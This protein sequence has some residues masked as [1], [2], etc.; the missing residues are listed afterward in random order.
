MTVKQG[1]Q[2]F[3]LDKKGTTSGVFVRPSQ[4]HVLQEGDEHVDEQ[5]GDDDEGG[6]FAV[7]NPPKVS[8]V[9]GETVLWDRG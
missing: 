1:K 9:M 8:S 6:I 4:V 3:E 7:P 2:Y 5:G